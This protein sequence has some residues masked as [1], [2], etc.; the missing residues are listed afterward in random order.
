MILLFLYSY[1]RLL[2][3]KY[4]VLANI[5]DNTLDAN[6]HKRI[7]TVGYLNP[8]PNIKSE[9]CGTVSIVNIITDNKI[10]VDIFFICYLFL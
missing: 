2:G 4:L 1:Y 9:M 6:E 5:K 3:L 8:T 10:D 7:N